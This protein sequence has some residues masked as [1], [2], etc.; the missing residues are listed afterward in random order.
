MTMERA[1]ATEWKVKVWDTKGVVRNTCTIT[2]S[3]SECAV[4]QVH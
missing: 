3:K 4:P 2:G 1:G